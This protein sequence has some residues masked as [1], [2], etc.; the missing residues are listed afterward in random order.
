MLLT[1]ISR[2]DLAGALV[3][4]SACDGAAADVLPGEE[5]LSLTWAFLAGGAGGVIAS[6]WPLSDQ[7]AP[8]CME[9]LYEQLGDGRDAAL[10]LAHAQRALI[11][12]EGV[13]G[14][15]GPQVWAAL[16]LVGGPA[17]RG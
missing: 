10:A 15:C 1:E 3:I 13:D 2:L 9:R 11:R 16:Q 7:V 8:V 4:L 5:V 12:G 6:L 14:P 17:A